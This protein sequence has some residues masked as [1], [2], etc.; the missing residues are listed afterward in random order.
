MDSKPI[1]FLVRHGECELSDS[2]VFVSWTDVPLTA[3]GKKQAK[4]AADILDEYDIKYIFS[5]PLDRSIE[6]ARIY[7]GEGTYIM[8]E[9]ALL[10][11][12]R[13]I[14]TGCL[15]SEA[16]DL[17]QLI[18]ENPDVHVPHGESRR[19][20][21]K[22]I[23]DFFTHSLD[24]A[25]KYPSAFFTHHSVIDVLNCLLKGKRNAKIV[26]LVKPGGIVAVYVDGEGYRLDA[27]HN[28]D[29]EKSSSMS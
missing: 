12:N 18:M 24:I 19:E 15:E 25:E 27:I 14:L 16:E 1:A 22:R 28:A 29:E 8:Q 23:G 3:K 10:P 9:R 4:E 11:W 2:G 17:L 5:S 20:A 6:T 26:N 13:G 7:A 21:E